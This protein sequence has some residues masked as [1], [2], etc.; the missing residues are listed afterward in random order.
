MPQGSFS[1][2]STSVDDLR[3]ASAA[4]QEEANVLLKAGHY[5]AAMIASYY[6]VEIALKVWLCQHNHHKKLPDAYKTHEL[7]ELLNAAGLFDQATNPIRSWKPGTRKSGIVSVTGIIPATGFKI[8]S[9]DENWNTVLKL[10]EQS[11]TALRYG[12]PGEVKK[13]EAEEYLNAIQ[14]APNGVLLWLSTLS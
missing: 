10:S 11:V 6:A 3:L 13:S 9:H 2:G 8:K 7:T 4:R 1:K 12:N 14:L 5:A